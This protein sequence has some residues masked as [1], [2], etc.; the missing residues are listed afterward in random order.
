MP[1]RVAR[2]KRIAG[3]AL[4]VVAVAAVGAFDYRI[5]S[6][7]GFSLFYLV[8]IALSAWFGGLRVAVIIACI[9]AG[10]WL[11]ADLRWRSSDVAVAVSLWNA[12][13]RLVI[14]VSHGVLIALLH[15]DRDRFR[16][17]AAR[18]SL[19]A[20]TDALTNLPNARSFLEYADEA[21]DQARRRGGGL[22]AI[23]LDLD[24]F[25]SFNDTLGHA[26]GD[27]ILV[28]VA[29]ILTRTLREGDIAAR[30]GGDEFVLLLRDASAETGERIAQSL[31]DSIRAL[32]EIYPEI[33]FGATAGI[34]CFAD[35]PATADALL[36]HADEA[37]YRGKSRPSALRAEQARES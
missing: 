10:S 22:C 28:E 33:G 8:P 27:A 5:G 35:A 36:R 7:I 2:E 16:R 37:M 18:E 9:A 14:Y 25:K 13:T 19:L 21:I 23:Y 3:I 12:F 34:V 15:R 24:R 29:R 6:E 20:R 1:P 4:S 11:V 30:L 17:L 26:A 31:C 32:G